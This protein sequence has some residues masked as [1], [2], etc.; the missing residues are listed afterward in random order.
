MH[1]IQSE[2]SW[3]SS[4]VIF[5]ALKN[6]SERFLWRLTY[7]FFIRVLIVDRR[8]NKGHKVTYHSLKVNDFSHFKARKL[9][10][11]FHSS[12]SRPPR[13]HAYVSLGVDHAPFGQRPH[14]L[15]LWYQFSSEFPTIAAMGEFGIRLSQPRM[16]QSSNLNLGLFSSSSIW[17][18]RDSGHLFQH[19]RRGCWVRPKFI[20]DSSFR[21]FRVIGRGDYNDWTWS[22]HTLEVPRN[23]LKRMEHRA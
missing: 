22:G 15:V 10:K 9:W 16:K 14:V 19:P 20:S 2:V 1:H 13:H 21:C 8:V 3:L 17:E 11:S 5:T 6:N 18:L 23:W 12:Q 4:A 7:F